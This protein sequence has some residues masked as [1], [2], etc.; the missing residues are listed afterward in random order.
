[1]RL[2][3]WPSLTVVALAA[4]AACGV[5]AQPEVP[6]DL[7]PEPAW[8]TPTLA[9]EPKEPETDWVVP[10]LHWSGYLAYELHTLRDQG[11]SSSLSNLLT[12][13][14]TGAT[15]IYQPWFARLNGSLNLTG[16]WT[17]N[18]TVGGFDSDGSL[19]ERIRTQERFFTGAGRLELFPLSRFPFEFHVEA[20]DSRTDSGLSS[21]LNFRTQNVGFSQRY[22]PVSGAYSLTGTF[23]R[24]EQ[25]GTGFR[26]TSDAFN[27]D[28]NTRW[29]SNDLTVSLSHNQA[30]SIGHEDESR[31][32]GLT[33]QH[34][35]APSAGVSVNSTV[36]WSRTEDLFATGVS[37]ISVL[38]GTS[39]GIWQRANSPLTLT[40][41]ARG[42]AL[43][44][45]V[46]DTGL[47]AVALTL[48]ANY[49]YN[50]NLRLTANGA[51]NLGRALGGNSTTGLN[52]SVGANYQ[53]DSLQFGAARYDWFGGATLGTSLNSASGQDSER[54]DAL[55][56][57]IGHSLTL[58][59]ALPGSALD[60]TANQSLTATHING[61]QRTDDPRLA[62]LADTR[63]M[64][65][66]VA[67]T[68]QLARGERSAYARASYN[69]S[70]EL[71]GGHA[72]F[73]LLNFQ[74]SGSVEFD[75]YSSLVGDLTYQRTNQ[76]QSELVDPAVVIARTGNTGTGAEISFIN[77]RLF[78]VPRLRF[79]SRLRLAQDVLRQ[80]GTLTFLPD[81]ETRLWEN[82]LDYAI[83]RIET[84]LVLRLSEV[85]G[86]RLQSLTLRI[87]RNFGQ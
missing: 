58:P 56:A 48:G 20:N 63:V 11:R 55:G 3:R 15:Y 2:T 82:R 51:L 79:L 62:A 31:F 69:D 39:I 75:R 46:G 42:I 68:W 47:D 77:Q 85:E 74:L 44:E 18:K 67:A 16:D 24:R 54:Q 5:H 43:R 13:N 60:L 34:N 66:G 83:G 84:Q 38:Q 87:Q 76:R 50:Q 86:R 64:V 59:V 17:E 10:P 9:G 40:G 25:S 61:T 26:S 41:S 53:G 57:Q 7:R 37:D 29:K 19:H 4:A 21:N 30:R 36:N 81:R 27:G 65:N 70:M 28:F 49:Q 52:G 23:D 78:G 73:Q 72:R 45:G 22:R 32:T 12:A 8:P 71:G 80:P 33:T 35:Y 6:G 1:M 14:L